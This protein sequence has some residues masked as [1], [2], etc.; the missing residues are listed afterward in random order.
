MVHCIL[1]KFSLE[2][3]EHPDN[4]TC[5][6]SDENYFKSCFRVFDKVWENKDIKNNVNVCLITGEEP[7]PKEKGRNKKLL[8]GWFYKKVLKFHRLTEM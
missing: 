6:L 5:C 7:G 8:S 4:G 1:I 3:T 2:Y